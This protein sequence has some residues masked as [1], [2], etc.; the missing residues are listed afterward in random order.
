MKQRDA[1][2]MIPFSLA[3]AAGFTEKAFSCDLRYDY[4]EVGRYK[5]P[6]QIGETV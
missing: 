6:N 4:P 3:G 5:M 1:V 2:R